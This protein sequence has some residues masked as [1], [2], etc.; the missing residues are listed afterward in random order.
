MK[1]TIWQYYCDIADKAPSETKGS[2]VKVKNGSTP[3]ESTV[4]AERR[5]ENRLRDLLLDIEDRIYQG[6][7]GSVK[8]FWPAM[9]LLGFNVISCSHLKS[10]QTG[11]LWN[12]G[13]YVITLYLSDVWVQFLCLNMAESVNDVFSS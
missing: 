13:I 7:L 2:T 6:T 8:V 3:L 11:L 5:M 9:F 1:L 12:M 10:K 4:S